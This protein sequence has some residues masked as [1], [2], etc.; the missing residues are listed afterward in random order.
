MTIEGT[1]TCRSATT[2]TALWMAVVAACT[3]AW[4]GLIPP[5]EGIVPDRAAEQVIE[6]LKAGRMGEAVERVE[7]MLADESMRLVRQDGQLVPIPTWVELQLSLTGT[8]E[9]FVNQYDKAMNAAAQRDLQVAKRGEPAVEMM[10][11]AARY[12][13]TT[14]STAAGADAAAIALA[15]GDVSSAVA[16][17]P[18]DAAFGEVGQDAVLPHAAFA[19]D[20]FRNF[21]PIESSRIV[22]VAARD[23]IVVASPLAVVALNGQGKALWT[24]GPAP[25][26]PL[27]TGSKKPNVPYEDRSLMRPAV[28]ADVLGTPRIVVARF[29][30]GETSSLRSYRASDGELI[31]DS[32]A[33]SASREWIVVGSPAAAGGI[34][35]ATVAQL[36]AAKGTQLMIVAFDLMSG[37]VLW[38]C[39]IGELQPVYRL[40][41][42]KR[43][44]RYHGAAMV[45]DQFAD[46]SSL[47]S[48][49]RRNVYAVMHGSCVAVDRFSGRLR[50]LASYPADALDPKRLARDKKQKPPPVLRRWRDEA[51]S[52]GRTV[53]IAPTDSDIVIAFD[54]VTGKVRWQNDAIRGQEL[55]GLVGDRAIFAGGSI[56]ALSLETGE[57]LWHNAPETPAVGPAFIDGDALGLLTERGLAYFSLERG[58]AV[59]RREAGATAN[60]VLLDPLLRTPATRNILQAAGLAAYFRAPAQS[61]NRLDRR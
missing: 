40:A 32:A 19:S 43:D 59:P 6:Q 7:A 24:A 31:W 58:L 21:L 52:D 56:A 23:F 46:T 53:V 2:A 16:L 30:D 41:A 25:V 33:L 60:V 34:V 57:L 13:W 8:R 20:W 1:M 45:I 49:D 35:Y 54:A 29:T 51:V 10:R 4:G 15:A 44:D 9:A 18:A 61:P 55:V 26:K 22:P 11:I 3:Q 48:V 14:A 39:E 50:W 42:L 37:G 27:L 36:D 38:Q 28:W 17:A 47:L 12:P 5:E